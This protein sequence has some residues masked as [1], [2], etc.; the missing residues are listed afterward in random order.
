MLSKKSKYAIKA[1]VCLAKNFA[2]KTPMRISQ[3]SES[4]KIPRKFLET[5]MVE[6]RNNGL[7]HSKMGSNGGYYLAKHQEEIVLS[8]V[9]RISG[10]PIAMLP[11]VSLNFYEPC[12]ECVNEAFCGLRDVAMEVRE[13]TLKILTKTSLSDI[14]AREENLKSKLELN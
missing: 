9:I 7:V 5:I 1:L 13:A 2:E 14:L 8:Q 4:E 6:L 12:E 3:I 11:C 10:G